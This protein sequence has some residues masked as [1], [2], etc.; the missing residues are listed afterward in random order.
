ASWAVSRYSRIGSTHDC[1]GRWIPIHCRLGCTCHSR[2]LLRALVMQRYSG[3]GFGIARIIFLLSCSRTFAGI[4]GR[5]THRNL[6][7]LV[8]Q[9]LGDKLSDQL[10]AFLWPKMKV[11]FLYPRSARTIFPIVRTVYATAGQENS[12]ALC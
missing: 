4:D 3:N 6:R 9:T 8:S 5:R 11:A 12:P 10:P 2:Y 1:N 7:L